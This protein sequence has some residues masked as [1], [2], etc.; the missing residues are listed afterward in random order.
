QELPLDA[1]GA[2]ERVEADV[3]EAHRAVGLQEIAGQADA[4]GPRHASFI[5]THGRLSLRAVSP[6]PSL[7][8][9][10]RRAVHSATGAPHK[11]SSAGTPRGSSVVARSCRLLV[12]V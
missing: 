7:P 2:I 8:P 11:S 5:Q 6:P 12:E 3:A 4:E 10:L 1:R 9:Y